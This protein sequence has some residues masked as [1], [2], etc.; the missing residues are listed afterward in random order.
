MALPALLALLQAGGSLFGG[1]SAEKSA[2]EEGRALKKQ[3]RLAAE[4]ART[5]EKRTFEDVTRAMA[6]QKLAFLKSGVSL[7]GSPLLSLKDT[8]DE[9][10]TQMGA[11]RR[12]G[13]AEYGLA[14]DK[15]GRIRREGRSKLISGLF[16]AGGSL[17]QAKAAGAFK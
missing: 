2:K 1:Y 13:E 4:E 9:G 16:E 8:E 11:I 14:R 12:R 6:R 17:G 7:E 3:G 10:K 5:E 15:A